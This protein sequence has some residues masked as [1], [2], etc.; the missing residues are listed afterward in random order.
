MD[1]Q[2][3]GF[4][5]IIVNNLS[6]ELVH[7]FGDLWCY[8]PP[9]HRVQHVDKLYKEVS[10]VSRGPDDSF[11]LILLPEYLVKGDGETETPRP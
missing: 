2:V 1:L 11:T 5:T 10:N 8:N 7:P 6:L 4:N 9:S 3:C